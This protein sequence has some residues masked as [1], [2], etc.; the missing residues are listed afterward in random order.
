[1]VRLIPSGPSDGTPMIKNPSH[2]KVEM[3]SS[4]VGYNIPLKDFNG[5]PTT[6][7]PQFNPRVNSSPPNDFPSIT[8]D[9][10]PSQ[11]F[12][13]QAIYNNTTWAESRNLILPS[14][15]NTEEWVSRWLKTSVEIF[16]QTKLTGFSLVEDKAPSSLRV[17]QARWNCW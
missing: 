7:N 1:M 9:T 8:Q 4:N 3:L 14:T 2:R 11:S 15:I 16:M 10:H 6:G 13:P 17:G 12:V 5:S